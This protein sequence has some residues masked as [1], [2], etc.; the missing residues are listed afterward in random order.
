MQKNSTKIELSR[1]LRIFCQLDIFKNYIF[2]N[3]LA[4][5]HDLQGENV[6]EVKICVFWPSK[7]FISACFLWVHYLRSYYQ[8]I[9]ICTLLPPKKG[10]N[11][12]ST[13]PIQG[14]PSQYGPPSTSNYIIH[15]ESMFV[16]LTGLWIEGDRNMMVWKKFFSK[17]FNIFNSVF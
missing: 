8:K 3:I 16:C 10:K 2:L 13:L 14:V 15:A 7:T 6:K 1:F 9:K 17:F 5:P 11:A 4:P 12:Y